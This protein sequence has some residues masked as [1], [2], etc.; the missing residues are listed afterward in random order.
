MKINTPKLAIIALFIGIFGLQGTALAQFSSI[1]G[2]D[3]TVAQQRDDILK[4]S[5]DTL[6]ALYQVLR[7]SS[8]H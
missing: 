4:A 8:A 1:F 7:G 3:K 5:N 6:K 2:S